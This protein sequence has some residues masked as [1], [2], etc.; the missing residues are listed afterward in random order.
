MYLSIFILTRNFRVVA[1]RKVRN[2]NPS[3]D[4]A[5]VVDAVRRRDLCR[6]R[7]RAISAFQKMLLQLIAL[8]DSV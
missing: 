3:Q 2:Q 1:K 5:T 6:P 7:R 4:P 8:L